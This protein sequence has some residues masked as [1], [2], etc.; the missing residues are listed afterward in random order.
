[1]RDKEKWMLEEMGL[2]CLIFDGVTHK[3]MFWGNVVFVCLSFIACAAAS[4]MTEMLIYKEITFYTG[5][6]QGNYF[7]EN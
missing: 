3:A 4:D 6:C 7:E 5:K 2:V 1:M